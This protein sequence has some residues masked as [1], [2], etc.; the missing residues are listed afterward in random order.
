MTRI[1]FNDD[2]LFEGRD[3]VRLPHNAVDL[4]FSYFDEKTYQR[5]FT[6]EKTFTADPDWSAREVF[7][8]FEGAMANTLV[9]LNGEDITRHPDG[10]TPSRRASPAASA[11]A[12]TT[13]PS[14]STGPRTPTS[15]PSAPSSTTS[16]M[17]ASTAR[18][19][20]T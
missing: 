17:R 12:R 1:D 11:P 5:P 19:G 9:R 16:P 6:Y 20:W 15:P 13:S 8:H 14:P 2:W 3:H 18:S 4:P 10:Y 7:L